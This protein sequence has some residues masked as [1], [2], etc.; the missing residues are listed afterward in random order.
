MGPVRDESY[1]EDNQITLG[2][3]GSMISILVPEFCLQ[4]VSAQYNPDTWRQN[5]HS[6]ALASPISQM[7]LE[8]LGCW[9]MSG[10]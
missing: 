8:I 7:R 9:M 1:D 6:L 5:D 10:P 2:E 4:F 3:E